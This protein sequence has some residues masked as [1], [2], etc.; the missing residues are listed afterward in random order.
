[1]DTYFT[2]ATANKRDK[3]GIF[4]I[5]LKEKRVPCFTIT[6]HYKILAIGF[7]STFLKIRLRKFPL[8]P[9]SQEVCYEYGL[10]YWILASLAFFYNDHVFT[11][12]FFYTNVQEWAQG[13]QYG[14][15]SKDACGQV[16]Q[17]EFDLWVPRGGRQE[18]IPTSC[19]LTSTW[20]L[21][22]WVSLPKKKL[23][24]REQA[25]KK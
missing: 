9:S 7:W 11:F 4:V 5:Q 12:F 1:M 2:V 25:Q 14:S 13:W 16:W 3:M 22:Q 19:P 6:L 20:M 21:W 23:T 24:K 8:I 17:A 10:S 18:P 15:V